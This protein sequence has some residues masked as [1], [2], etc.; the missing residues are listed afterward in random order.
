MLAGMPSITFNPINQNTLLVPL[1][2][3]PES[4]YL[5]F[6]LD[7]HQVGVL[8][9]R[10]QKYSKDL[11]IVPIRLYPSESKSS[12]LSVN[13]YN[14]SSHAFMNNAKETTR[15]EVNTYIRDKKGN[16]GTLIIDYLSNEFSMDPV[17]VFKH[18]ENTR[19]EKG[20]FNNRIHCMSI[21]DKI[22]L[23]VN[24]PTLLGRKQRLSDDLIRYSDKIYYKNGIYDKL[25]YDSTLTHA[26]TVTPVI[27]YD[28]FTFQYQGLQFNKIDSVFYF[29][30]MIHFVGGMWD[31]L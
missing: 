3:A 5:N 16:Y 4:T 26:N 9:R 17:N 10:I 8:N 11:E 12:Y 19:F 23:K 30:D 1:T 14:C 6:K 28:N 25:Y 2:L 31:N 27:V 15:C 7:D 18:K 13:V 20:I 29:T 21:K 24:I 22:K